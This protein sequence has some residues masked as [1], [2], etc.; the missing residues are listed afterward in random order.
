MLKTPTL[1]L[2]IGAVIAGMALAAQMI[3]DALPALTLPAVALL[4]LLAPFA[5]A[6]LFSLAQQ[7][8]SGRSPSLRTMLADV[9]DRALTTGL[10]A[11]MLS[12]LLLVGVRLTAIVF[13]LSVG[14][15]VSAE[16]VQSL[17]PGAGTPTLVLTTGAAVVGAAAAVITLFGLPIVHRQKVDVVTGLVRGIAL[18]RQT[19]RPIL[20]WAA[21][22]L[23]LVASAVCISPLVLVIGVPLLGLANWHGY[24]AA[25]PQDGY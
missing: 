1:S 19:G 22:M 16:F 9:H 10:F 2:G 4:T 12:F 15:A 8:H 17:L 20:L 13:A 11:L 14:P 24:Q 7:T 21:L 25:T 6:A 5:L 18:L 23:A 3:S